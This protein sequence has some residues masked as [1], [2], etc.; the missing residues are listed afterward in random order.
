MGDA[1]FEAENSLISASYDLKSDILKAGHHGSSTASSPTFLNEVSPAISVIEV[2]AG[3]DYGHPTRK[4]LVA[5]QEIGS[6]IYRTD[7]NGNIVVTTDGLSYSVSTQKQSEDTASTRTIPQ[8]STAAFTQTT[9]SIT[10][11]STASQG[12]FVGSSKSDKYHYPSCSA[13]KK[14]SPGNLVKFANSAEARTQ[15]YVPCGICHPA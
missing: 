8:T 1:G 6:K 10:S 11:T 4:T 15:G 7:T 9:S 3:N 14:I 12:P 2:D 5:L 13:A